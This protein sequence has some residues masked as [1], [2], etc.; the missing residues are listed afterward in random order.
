[1]EVLLVKSGNIDNR[2]SKILQMGPIQ[3]K[4]QIGNRTVRYIGPELEAIG[5]ATRMSAYAGPDRVVLNVKAND[6]DALGLQK[7][8]FYLVADMN[9][10]DLKM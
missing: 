3:V 10:S 1:M 6:K 4:S 5:Q 7:A 9:P 2:V 8:G